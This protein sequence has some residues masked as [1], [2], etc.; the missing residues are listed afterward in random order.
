MLDFDGNDKKCKNISLL[1]DQYCMIANI[2]DKV[3]SSNIP[4]TDNFVRE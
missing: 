1:K 4:K 2:T 3:I